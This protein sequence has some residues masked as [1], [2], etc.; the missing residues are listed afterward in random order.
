VVNVCGGNACGT[1]YAALGTAC[2]G[3]GKVCDGAGMCVGCNSSADCAAS[4]SCDASHV[5]RPFA[6]CA[7]LASTCGPNDDESC[8]AC[9]AIPGGSFD[10]GADPTAPATVS[11]FRLDRFEITVG[12]FRAYLAAYPASR[13]AAGAGAH[14]AVA[15]SGWDTAWDASLAADQGA[16]LAAIKCDA[17]YQ[18]WTDAPGLNDDKPMT[19]L[20]WFDAFAFCAWDGGRLPTEAEWNYASAAG[21][22]EREFPWSNPPSSITIDR[23]Y[24]V[25][26]CTGDGSAAGACAAA[27]IQK[28]G[29]RSPKGDGKWGHA[30]LAGNMEEWL[31]DWYTIPYPTPCAD[32][33]N[34]QAG[35]SRSIRGGS[36]FH[37]SDLAGS[38]PRA[39]SAPTT[40]NRVYGA[41]CARAR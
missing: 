13:P 34:L 21:A 25:Y 2:T 19:C 6:S 29:S 38:V 15:G 16:L 22:E 27:D 12:R 28:V 7:A 33:A 11:D 5:C 40:R 36:W 32:C 17:T 8:C 26:D 35:T 24:A 23:T 18:T 14:P 31:F 39:S 3:G 4:E 10:R 30:D 37:H 20:S 1:F 41:R 9:P